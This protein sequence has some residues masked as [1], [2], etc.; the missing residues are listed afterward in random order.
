MRQIAGLSLWVGNASD[1]RNPELLDQFGIQ[2]VVDLAVNE[3]SALLPREVVYCRFPLFDGAQNP[4]WLLRAA[5]DSVAHFLRSQ[6]RVLV[7]CS[8]GLSRSPSISAAA[9]A[10]TQGCSPQEAIR[11]VAI[12]GHTD[13][14]GVLWEDI[15]QVLD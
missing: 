1:A 5:V 8:A 10:V 14:S 4:E 9:I 7:A 12:D 3:S 15:C 2:A 11:M 6:I 13:V